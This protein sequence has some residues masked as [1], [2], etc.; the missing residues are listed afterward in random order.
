MKVLIV[1]DAEIDT[2]VCQKIVESLGYTPIAVRSAI[3]AS[4]LLNQS[5]APDIII[6]DWMMPEM[7]G[8]ALCKIIRRANFIID[9]FI[10]IMTSNSDKHA[11]AEALNA[12]ADDFISKPVNRI[13]MEAKLKLGRRLIKTQLELLLANQR[14]SEKLEFDAVTGLK[15][16]QAG[17][18]AIAASLSRLSRHEEKEGLLIHCLLKFTSN[19]AQYF[20][21]DLLDKL[22]FELARNLT[23]ALR[24][25]DVMVRFKDDEF[26]FF[27]ESDPES[28]HIVLSRIERAI[29]QSN[30]SSESKL[31]ISWLV[32]GI[33]I[34]YEQAL[35]AIPVL[36]QNTEELLAKLT[37]SDKNVGLTYLSP[38]LTEAK[39]L[40][41]TQFRS[42]R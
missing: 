42:T 18:Q 15:S 29:Q 9:P 7:D 6:L 40:D 8:M 27:A 14:L 20:K 38:V 16:R 21:H 32:A 10:L 36:L 5:G 2:L 17:L 12:G 37:L 30:L 24:Q 13:D 22:Y 33:V 41:F 28:H 3:E 1:D 39:V 19:K 25:S 31:N 34:T 26:L 35:T 4:E 23:Q 11:E